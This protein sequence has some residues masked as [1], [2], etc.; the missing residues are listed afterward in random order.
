MGRTEFTPQER[1]RRINV[2]LDAA[3]NV[4][5]EKGYFK[6]TMSDIAT[7]SEISRRTIYLYFKNKDELSYEIVYKAFLFLKEKI[8]SAVDISKSGY[9]RLMDIQ[10]AY[11]EYNS[12]RL[13]DVVFTMYFDFKMN[14]N[15]LEDKQIK[16]CLILISDIVYPCFFEK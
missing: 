5:I 4:F 14:T 6:T 2:I 8:V 3:K 11:L 7:A 1:E 16:V 9:E 15:L 13:S 10:S 12:T